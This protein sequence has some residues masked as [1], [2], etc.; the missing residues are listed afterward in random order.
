METI[1][2]GIKPT[3][4]LHLG[5]YF[6]AIK[7][8]IELANNSE[9][10]LLLFLADYHAL[11]YI[12][13]AKQLKKLT[14]DLACALLA[15]GADKEN[16]TLYLQSDIPQVF[17]LEWILSNISAKGLLNRAHAYKAQCAKNIEDG[18]DC[19]QN[20]NMGLFCYPVLMA[21]DI[22][23]ANPSHVPVGP[24]Q[25]Q[26]LEITK[27]IS[28]VFN[29]TYGKFFA[30]IKEIQ[31]PTAEIVGLDGRK[32]SKSYNNSISLFCDETTLKKQIN[33][34]VT[35]SQ[36]PG[37]PKDTNC[38]IF[39]MF[40]LFATEQQKT[41][42]ANQ[43]ASGIGWGEVKKQTFA[44]ANQFIAPMREKYNFYQNNPQIVDQILKRGKEKM[45]ALAEHNMSIIRKLI[46]K[47]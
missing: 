34:I 46:G 23:I 33:K 26:H 28:R 44:L 42:M 40:S 19:D 47:Y 1:L 8:S 7:P 9:S 17:E 24:D 22:L 16:I 39:K 29:N 3:G 36:M 20:I 37:E 13:D 25:I 4:E 15:C 45:T 27:E 41:D 31:H 14:F 30:T 43:F 6:G 11:N 21:A 5:N 38:N 2:T 35:N 10:E 12:K 32:M 18:L